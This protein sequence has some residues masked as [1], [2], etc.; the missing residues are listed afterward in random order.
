M[1]KRKE[2]LCTKCTYNNNGW[3]NA[4]KTN[5]GLKDLVDCEYRKTDNLIKLQ[6]Y[7]NQK[8]WEYDNIDIEHSVVNKGILKGLEIALQIMN[9]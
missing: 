9:K 3:C 4:R 6:E 2:R 5:K 8:K 1:D 7:F